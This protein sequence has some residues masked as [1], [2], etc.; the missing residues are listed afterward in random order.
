MKKWYI[1]SVVVVFVLV[2]GVV[3]ALN[4]ERWIFLPTSSELEAGIIGF[5]EVEI[6]AED[7]EIPWEI[8][9]LPGGDFLITERPG[10]LLIIGAVRKE[11]E[12]EDVTQKAEGGLLGMVLHPDFEENGQ[13]YL[14]ITNSV[15]GE[16]SN[17]IERYRLVNGKLNQKRTILD[18]IPGA[19]YHDG[20]RMEFGPDGYL[21]VTT[22]DATHSELAQDLDSLAG[23]ILRLKDDGNI[24]EDNPF[25]NYVYSYGHR[26]PQG[27]AWDSNENL[28]ST[29]HG[30]S[31]RLSGLDELNL[32]VKGGNYG[33]PII[34]GDETRDG[35][36]SPKV[37]SGPDET[38]APA[39]LA[40]FEGRL[41]FTG[42]RGETLYEA[43]I[44]GTEVIE[45]KAHFRKEFG[46]LRAVVVGPDENLY[47]STSNRGG[48]G[49]VRDGDDK[50]IRIPF[51]AFVT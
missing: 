6:F 18:G 8:S 23:K 36:I 34:Q 26:N 45:L 38:W 51:E 39:G 3:L 25:E 49:K 12:I 44:D 16:I 17:R 28:W 24:P 14:Y 22:G 19:P 32:I 9:F 42:L 50:I 41:F 10:R 27:L 33:W 47:I 13:I 2:V 35:M 31:G 4:L 21:Y 37:H 11:I 40:Y 1:V 29:E 43:R 15:D 48:R 7:L 46:R 20:G 5:T 30:R